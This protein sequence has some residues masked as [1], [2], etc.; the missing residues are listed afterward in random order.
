M[1]TT[2]RIVLAVLAA[3]VLIPGIGMTVAWWTA[4]TPQNASSTIVTLAQSPGGSALVGGLVIDKLAEDANPVV[5]AVLESQRDKLV[6]LAAAGVRKVAQFV[7]AGVSVVFAAVMDGV[8]AK[9]DLTPVVNAALAEIH[10]VIDVIPAQLPPGD[11]IVIDIDGSSLVPVSTGVRLLGFW[12]LILLVG[13]ALLVAAAFAGLFGG[14]RRWRVSGLTLAIVGALWIVIGL[15]A[16]GVVSGFADD[17]LQQQLLSTVTGQVGQ[18]I[19]IV[20]GITLAVGLIV[21]ILSFLRRKAPAGT[22]VA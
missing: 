11:T 16:P 3:V 14:L 4:G 9:I 5:K 15:V 7:G 21:T 2:L 13:V 8:K 19:F 17:P 1:R 22:V 20:A 6:P 18:K 10:G 12:W